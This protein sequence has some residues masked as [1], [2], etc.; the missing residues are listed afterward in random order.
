MKVTVKNI[1][2]LKDQKDVTNFS[3][4][5]FDAIIRAINGNLSIQDNMNGS[6]LGVTFA[7]ANANTIIN[8]GLNR[9]PLGYLALSASAAMDLYDGTTASTTSQITLRS[10]ATGFVKIFIF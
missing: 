1:S 5:N 2:N 6:I 10:S 9:I 8:H 7:S 4:Q 3:S